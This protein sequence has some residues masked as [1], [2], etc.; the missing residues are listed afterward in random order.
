MEKN[1]HWV[2]GEY[3]FLQYMDSD[4]CFKFFRGWEDRYLWFSI[5]L[6]WSFEWNQTS[7]S[8]G[9]RNAHEFWIS[10]SPISFNIW[11]DRDH[12]NQKLCHRTSSLVVGRCFLVF[13]LGPDVPE[14]F[15]FVLTKHNI[16][17][18]NERRR[19]D[20]WAQTW[21]W[22]SRNDHNT[23]SGKCAK[24][25]VLWSLSLWT[26]ADVQKRPPL[27]AAQ[28]WFCFCF[29]CLCLSVQRKYFYIWSGYGWSLCWL[30]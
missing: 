13:G 21:A 4:Q 1:R 15:P 14:E 27:V 20:G 22:R 16:Y 8:D 17:P 23:T 18:E 5:N 25:F 2:I 3:R 6:H 28:G 10:N 7:L 19:C 24:T 26:E 30:L 29:P 12:L 11:M 9:K